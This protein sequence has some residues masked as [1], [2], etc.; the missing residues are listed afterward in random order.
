MK[1]AE[2]LIQNVN[3]AYH[4]MLQVHK[5]R[6]VWPSGV[7][8]DVFASY[9]SAV[10][11]LIALKLIAPNWH[12]DEKSWEWINGHFRFRYE[13]RVS[14]ERSSGCRAIAH[15][16]ELRC[17]MHFYPKADLHEELKRLGEHAAFFRGR[18]L[19]MEEA[20]ARA[21]EAPNLGTLP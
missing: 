12:V 7:V 17:W 20:T 11:K 9:S 8:Q 15:N 4:T 1:K 3:A 6:D 14:L 2:R 19:E 21:A 5:L 10:L 13:G 16:I 18:A